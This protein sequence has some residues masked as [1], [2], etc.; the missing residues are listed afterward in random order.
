[1]KVKLIYNPVAGSGTFKNYLD[2]IID[3]FQRKGLQVEPY[4]TNK[5]KSLDKVLS[6]MNQNEYE[7][8]LVAGGDGTINQAVNAIIK[9]NIDL[10][11][12]IFPVGTSNDYAK[13]FNIPNSVE[14]AVD[15]FIKDNYSYSDVGLFNEKYFINVASLGGIIDTSHKTNSEF[16]N[17][18]GVL[19]YY[20]NGI[21]NLPKL[22][23][24]SVRIISKEKNFEGEIF[25]MLIM[26]G[27]SAGGFNKIAPSAS[28]NDGLLEVIVF[29][30]CQIHELIHL[31]I[32]VINGEHVKNSNVIHFK[33]NE[34]KIDCDSD[35][36]TDIDGEKGPPFPINIK[37][38]PNKIKVLT[39]FQYDNIYV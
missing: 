2:Y 29:K 26:N 36:S 12:G 16:K 4:R 17:I 32:T 9:N 10:P 19:A 6:L 14:K 33:T 23:P 28:V 27:K 15:I 22:K 37:V 8:I 18:L 21:S 13:Y 7:K 25:F 3:R 34:M 24:I 31:F 38:V 1:M 20:I 39:P 5:K 35:V 30:K 11:L